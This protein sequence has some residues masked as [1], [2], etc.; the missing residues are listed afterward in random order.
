MLRFQSI[1]V[2]AVVLNPRKHNKY[3]IISLYRAPNSTVNN[4][5]Q[6]IDMLLQIA[7]NENIPF[8]LSGDTNIDL[9]KTDR[10]AN[11]YTKVIQKFQCSQK[12]NGATRITKSSKTCIDHIITNQPTISCGILDSSVSDHMPI[13][14]HWGSNRNN[15]L[16]T[17]MMFTKIDIEKVKLELSLIKEATAFQAKDS[18]DKNFDRLHNE[19]MKVLKN[20]EYKTKIKTFARNPWINNENIELRKL[21]AKYR[22]KFLTKPS[23]ETEILYRKTQKEYKYSLR[24]SKQVYYKKQL[25]IANKD[26]KKVWRVINEVLSRK[27]KQ[28]RSL[29]QIVYNGNTYIGD[30]Q[31][32]EAFNQYY[33]NIPIEVLNNI[34][35]SSKCFKEFLI[36]NDNQESFELKI[37]DK[38]KI[39]DI[40]K[41][42]KPKKS[43]GPY[44]IS[45][46]TIKEILPSII[47]PLIQNINQSLMTGI[48][49]KGLKISKISPLYK[50]GDKQD[51]GNW[52]PVSQQSPF[53]KFYEKAY[54]NQFEPFL[55]K[56]NII[57]EQQYGFQKKHSTGHAIINTIHELEKEL[58]EGKYVMV[59]VLD[60]KKAFDTVSIDILVEKIKHYTK[61]ERA[62]KWLESFFTERK[63]IT[64]WKEEISETANCHKVSI[65]QGSCLGPKAFTLFVN[66]IKN[67]TKSNLVLFADDTISILSSKDIK[68]LETFANDEL[69]NIKTYYD[70]NKLAIN[71]EKS[72]YMI[73]QPSNKKTIINLD[74]KMGN[75]NLQEL[76]EVQY[77]GI[78]IDKRLR[79]GTQFKKVQQKLKQGLGA[80]IL[81]KDLLDKKAKLSIYHSLFHSHLLY[82][83]ISWM[84]FLTKKQINDLK[85]LQK[86]AIRVIYGAPINSH[87]SN[88]FRI[89]GITKV[90]KIVENESIMLIRNYI[91]KQLPRNLN[92]IIDDL[93][94]ENKKATRSA[95][96]QIFQ[97][98]I[99]YQKQT[100]LTKAIIAW[101]GT[102]N[103]NKNIKQLKKLKNKLVQEQNVHSNCNDRNCRPCKLQ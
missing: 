87:T 78:T 49:P 98:K 53:S 55:S 61:N 58:K 69:N 73:L 26:P 3:L 97:P 52:R 60:L 63:Q 24:K 56:N 62:T 13:Y 38:K 76:N 7:T 77:L 72:G 74:I 91:N 94:R 90:D 103:D 21:T 17:D 99:K 41:D 95:N 29:N 101:N 22:R 5:L 8:I 80:L 12:I 43:L 51:P 2:T 15:Q 75:K 71:V 92:N 11:E 9:N 48:F 89:S 16:V 54:L 42:I 40:A 31:I 46:N 32:A 23:A 67:S 34:E 83:S 37:I 44:G 10:Y 30:H 57:Y 70:S 18:V 20:C 6:E 33:H 39:Q 88:L 66:D 19:T 47:E 27:I 100:I 45:S 36:G 59:A 102:S 85:V 93:I 65:I 25:E 81:S 86:K 50:K 79:F 1:E 68:S 84:S 82:A 28:K 14:C 35:K 64:Q 4:S 96:N